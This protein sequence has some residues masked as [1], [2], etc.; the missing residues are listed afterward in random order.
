MAAPVRR[1]ELTQRDIVVPE[2][3]DSVAEIEVP[4]R[5]PQARAL[6]Q[7][8]ATPQLQVPALQNEPGELQVPTP[9]SITAVTQTMAYR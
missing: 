2:V 3:R 5:L 4:E 9:A 6:P 7:R 8:T 1:A